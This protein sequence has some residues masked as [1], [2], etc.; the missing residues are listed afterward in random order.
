MFSENNLELKNLRMKF[1]R[2]FIIILVVFFFYL[3]GSFVYEIYCE[4]RVF[5]IE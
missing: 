2:F 4:N 3:K 5:L 1:F